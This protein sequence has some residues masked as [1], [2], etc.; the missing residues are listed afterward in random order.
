MAEQILEIYHLLHRHFGPQKW[1]P[2]ETRLE[3]TVG[4]VLT[5]NTNWR[6]VE[7]A[8]ANLKGAGLLS[9]A[10]LAEAPVEI[11]A[12]HIRPSGYY[13]LK[14]GRLKNLIA[15]IGS[16]DDD[17]ENFLAGDLET[18]RHDLLAVKG[19]GPETADSI[20]LYAAE[21]PIFVVDAYTHRILS[22][23]EL[24]WAESDYHEIQELFMTSLPEDVA[25]YNEFHA[26]LVRLGKEFCLKGRPKCENCPLQGV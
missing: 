23:H 18:L 8:I 11:L 13:N 15:A 7:K 12:D 2:G 17:L 21:K 22:R 6:N 3:I 14:S 26:L 16:S 1:W 24:I 19:I 9:L 10:A 25:L 4:A 20:I 5:Q